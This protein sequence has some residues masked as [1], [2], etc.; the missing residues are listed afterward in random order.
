MLIKFLK[1]SWV[2]LYMATIPAKL[3]PSKKCK[4]LSENSTKANKKR[5]DNGSS[6]RALY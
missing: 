2:W 4:T 5:L 6:G 3:A 1:I